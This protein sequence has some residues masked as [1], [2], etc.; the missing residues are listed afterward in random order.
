MKQ[1]FDIHRLAAAARLSL[2]KEEALALESDLSA[3]I[4]FADGLSAVS[5]EALSACSP[6]LPSAL[7]EDVPTEGLKREALLAAAPSTHEGYVTV[8]RLWED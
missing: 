2:T 6:S 4:A 8:P 1:I 3:M 7:R 5:D